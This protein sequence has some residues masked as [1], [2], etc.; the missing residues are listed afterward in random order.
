M[1]PDPTELRDH[2]WWRP[3]PAPLTFPRD[4]RR[5]EWASRDPIPLAPLPATWDDG[6]GMGR[7]R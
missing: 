3:G 5:Y 2:W 1:T 7:S 6:D 4:R